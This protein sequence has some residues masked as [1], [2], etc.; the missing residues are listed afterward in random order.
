MPSRNLNLGIID[1]TIIAADA[2]IAQGPRGD[3]ALAWACGSLTLFG[4]AAADSMR[5]VAQLASHRESRVAM[6]EDLFAAA[7]DA[8][9][10]TADDSPSSSPNSERRA[11]SGYTLL[12]LDLEPLQHGQDRGSG[13][14][15]SDSVA[16]DQEHQLHAH[17]R[18]GGS[19]SYP[20]PFGEEPL[21]S[22][23]STSGNFFYRDDGYGMDGSTLFASSD[24]AFAAPAH[25]LEG[26]LGP[27][28]PF[29]DDAASI[30]DPPS[31]LLTPKSG[32]SRSSGGIRVVPMYSGA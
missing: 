22:N 3:S 15:R 24:G 2:A 4:S 16:A 31:E 5:A 14:F 12:S 11:P 30:D 17:G 26:S 19:S 1:S 10:L 32:R 29:E 23:R 20:P 28:H 9:G 18:G 6:A 13:G 8:S 21:P 7:A 27:T 25:P